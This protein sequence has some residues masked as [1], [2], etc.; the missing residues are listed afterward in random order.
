MTRRTPVGGERLRRIWSG[1]FWILA[2][3]LGAITIYTSVITIH[4]GT[5]RQIAAGL[6]V[7]A[8]AIH[9]ST[10]ASARLE[11]LA[12]EAFAPIGPL[13]PARPEPSTGR[14]TINTLAT[15]QREGVEC[16]C[17]E[18]VPARRFC[19]DHVRDR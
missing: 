14:T 7:Q 3:L 17:R 9:A 16:A 18:L 19:H 5:Q 10:L 11:R 15:R 12:L 8:T 6:I 13:A 1:R 2:A 4:D